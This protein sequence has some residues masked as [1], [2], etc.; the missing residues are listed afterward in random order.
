MGLTPDRRRELTAILSLAA[1]VFL[2]LSLLPTPLT[3]WV[4]RFIGSLLWKSLGVGSALLPLLL[5][6]LG[7]ARFGWLRRLDQRRTAVLVG[8]LVILVPFGIA[9]AIGLE[10]IRDH[11]PNYND[12]S[13]GL[14]IV[15]IAPLFL[16]VTVANVLGTAGAVILAL[17]GLAALTLSTIGWQPLKRLWQSE[18]AAMRDKRVYEASFSN[19]APAE[20][21]PPPL[22]RLKAPLLAKKKKPP[23]SPSVA[24]QV[25]DEQ[26]FISEAAIEP[27]PYEL[28]DEAE[29]NSDDEDQTELDRLGRVL[30]DTLKTFKVDATLGRHRSTGP[31][32]TQFEVAPAAGVKV[33]RIAALADDLALK[34]EAQSIR[35]VAPIPGKAFVGVEVPNPSPRMVA[36]SELLAVP[37]WD[38][39]RPGLP[40]ALG[41]DLEGR[42]VM[43]D[44][45][46]MPHL[47][48][49]G[50]TGSGKSIC[51][52]TIITSLIHRYNDRQ[53]QLLMIDPKM[54]E[55]TVYNALPHMRHSVVTNNKDAAK[56]LKWVMYEMEDRYK[57]F[58]VN[59]VRNLHEFN[60]KVKE[61]RK[62]VMPRPERETLSGLEAFE[63]EEK[64]LS[65]TV[66]YDGSTLPFIVIIVEELADLMM[67]VQA[68][69]EKP[70]AILA[71]KARA[72]G[73][74]LILATQRP[75]VNVITGLIKA[76][77]PSRIAFRVASKVDSRTILDQNG[78]ETL[79]GNGD[80]LFLPP[81]KSEPVRLQ[82][83]YIDTSETERVTAWYSEQRARREKKRGVPA[84]VGAQEDILAVVAAR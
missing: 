78:A 52:N 58:N 38:P 41:T 61:G 51:V 15:G 13:T 50:A 75:S 53:L 71:Q 42:P 62:V 1:G 11:P 23:Q 20:T 63:G 21:G 54:V 83:A 55:L 26:A 74:H 9:I 31:V 16:A 8:G 47:L 76:N 65:P 24:A 25:G 33:G 36:L 73:I 40:I 68:E 19:A 84:D 56:A 77:F 57:L 81:G 70:L 82:G 34:M 80:M 29:A 48:I 59:N 45:S 30:I 4:G 60:R 43:A 79:L 46:K 44:L 12:W 17:L 35:I 39:N 32:V 37:A 66:T 49:A 22:A 2:G 6:V 64:K 69:V 14:K 5:L 18:S 10:N 67:T 27:F 72:T 28:L 7:I 3:G